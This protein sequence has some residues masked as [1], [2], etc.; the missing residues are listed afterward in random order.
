MGYKLVTV[1][2]LAGLVV[3]FIIQNVA[4]VE[5]RFLFWTMQ[6]SKALL[7][8]LL[9]AVG[10]IMGWALNGYLI[11]RQRKAIKKPLPREQQ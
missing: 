3:L 4:V 1:L 9:F 10:V 5:V 6:I 11:Y 2:I 8:F 7:I